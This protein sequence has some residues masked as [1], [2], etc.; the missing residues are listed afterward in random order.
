MN[1]GESSGTNIVG[2]SNGGDQGVQGSLAF[3]N[4]GSVSDQLVPQQNP[5]QADQPAKKK[6]A[7]PKKQAQ[8]KKQQPVG[9]D[10]TAL[11]TGR[12]GPIVSGGGE[13][14]QINTSTVHR[15]EAKQEQVDPAPTIE[16]P[17]AEQT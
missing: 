13:S 11:V 9:T 10:A 2:V 15:E 17:P 4:D 7:A 6:R 12:D 16:Q 3:G 5:G 1:V 14:E 8:P